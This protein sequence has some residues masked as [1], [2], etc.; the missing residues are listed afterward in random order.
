MITISYYD[1]IRF[2]SVVMIRFPIMTRVMFPSF[3]L[4]TLTVLFNFN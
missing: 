3:G 2:A 4:I 1:V